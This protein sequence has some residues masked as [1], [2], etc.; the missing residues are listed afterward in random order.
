MSAVI[1]GQVLKS[2]WWE[3]Y[4]KPVATWETLEGYGPSLGLLASRPPSSALERE[5]VQGYLAGLLEGE[6]YFYYTR[7]TH[8]W[9]P[10]VY[11][12]MCEAAPVRFFSR[13]MNV[14]VTLVQRS[15]VS[16]V[17]GLRAVL[18]A[19]IIVPMLSGKRRLTSELFVKR[20]YR[21]VSTITLQDYRL[22][23]GSAKQKLLMPPPLR[24]DDMEKYPAV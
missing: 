21:V 15:Y 20:G 10:C 14:T 6:G 5:R 3:S 19:R 17:K 13:V 2:D 1:T 23:Y 11:L 12:R 7:Y 9:Y 16:R 24:L 22:I 8:G 18:L 4:V